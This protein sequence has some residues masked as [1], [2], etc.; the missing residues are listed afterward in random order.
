MAYT[1]TIMNQVLKYIPRHEFQSCVDRHQGDKKVRN[2]SCW[3]Q[4]VSMLFGQLTQRKSLRDLGSSLLIK[5]ASLYHWGVKPF[6]FSSL[7]RANEKRSHAI[8]ET[9]FNKLYHK[10]LSVPRSHGFRFKNP[11]YAFDATIVDLCLSL[12]SWAPFR[13]KKA[14]IKLHTLLNL[15]GNIPEFVAVK[16]AQVHEVNVARELNLSKGSILALDRGYE[17]FGLYQD[18]HNRD[19]FFVNRFRNRRSFKITER[20]KANKPKGLMADQTI[21]FTAFYA[22]KDC[23]TPL[24]RIVF[25]DPETGK[26]L[27]FITNIFHLS[28]L[29]VASIYK[30][31]WQIELFFKW[32]K[33][34]LKIKSFLGTSENAVKTQIWIA[35]IAYLVIFWLKHVAK[36]SLSMM[37][38][39]RLLQLSLTAKRSLAELLNPKLKLSDY[40][41]IEK[42]LC[43]NNI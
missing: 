12:F 19:L 16:P 28:A 24:R 25:K 37:Q 32:I 29:T 20:R 26:K 41:K 36:S 27:I 22:K 30:A 38:I 8:Y 3:S 39:T 14:G 1:N 15:E 6:H 7:A 34:N 18:L 42:Q 17:D 13:G 40:L 5:V 33:Q 31:R 10:I 35:L 11:L 43:F 23:P 4:F 21:Q 9:F 2:L